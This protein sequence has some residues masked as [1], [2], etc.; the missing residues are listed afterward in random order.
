MLASVIV[1]LPPQYQLLETLFEFLH[2]VL[3]F[4]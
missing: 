3:P 1:V 2:N 4:G